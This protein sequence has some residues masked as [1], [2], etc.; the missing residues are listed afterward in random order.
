MRTKVILPAVLLSLLFFS[1][2]DKKEFL[3]YSVDEAERGARDIRLDSLK[4]D[5]WILDRFEEQNTV[6]LVDTRGYSGGLETLEYLVPLLHSRGIVELDLWFIPKDKL[7]Q[8][9]A[10][11]N[12]SLFYNDSAA[13]L[14]GQAD[15]LYLYEEHV[16]FLR[17]LYDFNKTLGE[18][19]DKMIL[20]DLRDREGK[21]VIYTYELQEGAANLLIQ[22]PPALSV[23]E[24]SNEKGLRTKMAQ[25]F[26]LLE[27]EAPF[28]IMDQDHFL[29]EN[30]QPYPLLVLS[31]PGVLQPCHPLE[32]GINKGNYER[33][34]TDFPD[35][36]ISAPPFLA[37]SLMKK[38]QK[39][40]L[41]SLKRRSS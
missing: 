35:Q 16:D 4:P 31:E 14:S 5:R 30:D 6:A 32:E 29:W 19:E 21:G 40:Y 2:G 9:N 39:R 34:L 38:A 25:I 23:L 15:Y 36:V 11:L 24:R 37:I 7:I 13:D 27:G 22:S 26:P 41:K 8:A 28:F 33:A 1:C 17:Y 10:L 12:A 20:T 3:P 18:D